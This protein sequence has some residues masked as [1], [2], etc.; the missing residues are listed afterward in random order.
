M[1]YKLFDIAED[2]MYNDSMTRRK[3][4][5]TYDS[6]KRAKNNT[7]GNEDND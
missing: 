2:G 7:S 1:T 5:E 6:K 4:K 3:E